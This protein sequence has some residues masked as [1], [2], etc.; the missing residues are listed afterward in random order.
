MD[1]L[2]NLY[3]AMPAD[4]DGGRRELLQTIPLFT[5][6]RILMSVRIKGSLSG[7]TCQC[8]R[9]KK[10]NCLKEN[11]I[12]IMELWLGLSLIM[13]RASTRQSMKIRVIDQVRDRPYQTRRAVN[14]LVVQMQVIWQVGRIKWFMYCFC[15]CLKL[16]LMETS[17]WMRWDMINYCS[18]TASLFVRRSQDRTARKIK[19][20]TCVFDG[21]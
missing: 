15:S 21:R 12:K 6:G 8:V 14:N 5:L 1:L 13:L 19:W 3:C 11:S 20:L 2:I 10:W 9:T 16:N 4:L 7:R 18:C 17:D